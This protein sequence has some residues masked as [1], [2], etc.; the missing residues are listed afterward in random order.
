MA[1]CVRGDQEDV[2]AAPCVGA[3]PSHGVPEA[4]HRVATGLALTE[5]EV[6]AVELLVSGAVA[7]AHP[8]HRIDFK[9]RLPPGVG[10]DAVLVAAGV[11]QDGVGLCRE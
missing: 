2:V 8:V 3:W 11:Q 4:V 6:G 9:R 7:D 10:I 1:V 5:G